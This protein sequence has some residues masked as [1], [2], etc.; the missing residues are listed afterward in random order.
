MRAWLFRRF[1]GTCPFSRPHSS[2]FRKPPYDPGRSDFP[3]PV[4]TLACPPAAFP[5][6]RR[7]KRWF[8]STPPGYGLLAGLGP[9]LL[10]AVIPAQ[11]PGPAKARQVP[12]A[13]SHAPGVTRVRC[14]VARC[15]GGLY[16]TFVARTSPCARP[17]PSRRLRFPYTAGLCR[18]SPVPAGRWPFPALSLQSLYGCLDPYPAALLL[19]S[20]KE[21]KKDKGPSKE[22]EKNIYNI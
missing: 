6:S 11:S 1:R 2:R 14:S 13:P 8:L 10:I 21:G 3:S 9:S 20:P 12:R 18:L 22:Q 4:L 17:N 15:S 5:S 16:P 19:R 7:L